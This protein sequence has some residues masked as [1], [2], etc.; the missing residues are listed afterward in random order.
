MPSRER[1][2]SH[3]ALCAKDVCLE[4]AISVGD[5]MNSK[6]ERYGTRQSKGTAPSDVPA[7]PPHECAQNARLRIDVYSMISRY[8]YHKVACGP[9]ATPFAL[10][11]A[12][13]ANN[14]LFEMSFGMN[15]MK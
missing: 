12:D 1:Q 13:V 14:P 5:E 3:T 2:N 15:I 11:A 4:G 8:V 10:D 6:P 7:S 9:Y